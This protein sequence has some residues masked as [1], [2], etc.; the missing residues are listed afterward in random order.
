MFGKHIG[1]LKHPGYNGKADAPALPDYVGAAKA[2]AQGN[3]DLA[4]QT[5]TANRINQVTPYGQLQYHFIGQDVYGN[6]QYEAV[7]GL[8]N[9]EGDI[10]SGQEALSKQLLGNALTGQQN[11]AKALAN[12][13]VDLSNLPSTGINPGQTY[14]DAIMKRL[15]PQITRENAASDVQLANQGIAPGTEAW[16]AAKT[17]LAEN[18]NDRLTSAITQGMGV[19]LQANQQAF[20]QQAQNLQLPINLINAARSGS[21]VQNPQQ[22]S[23]PQQ[24]NVAGADI[25]GATQ[26][27]YNAAL[28]ATNAQNQ[29][30]SNFYGGLLGLGGMLFS[31][32]RMKENVAEIG[33]LDNGLK[34]YEFEYKPEFKD[35]A[36]YGKFIGVMAQEVEKLIPDAVKTM[37]NGFKAVN[38]SM[39]GA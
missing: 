20:N 29:A 6:P 13:M 35:I 21:Q 11:T 8:S 19:G 28:G 7:S 10:L 25:L 3:L 4:R 16:R 36:G 22:I 5:A 33:N 31:D 30:T 27:G 18:Q 34:L 2:T 32:E 12:P 15:Q 1:I 38:Y 9:A 24:A 14:S 23:T 17:Q 37:A 26:S 39:L